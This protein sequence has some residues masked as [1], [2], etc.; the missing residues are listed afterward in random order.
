MVL[1]ASVALAFALPDED[2]DV[3]EALMLQ[4]EDTPALA[5]TIWI[6]EIASGLRT[7]EQRERLTEATSRAVLAQFAELHIE[8]EHPDAVRLVDL[9]RETGL[10]VYDAS[11]LALC[12]QHKLPLASFDRRLTSVALTRG[13][14]IRT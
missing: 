9:A 1:D 14:A 8:F 5:P 2:S 6:Y 10:S 3:A 12:E 4:L 13:I 7:A 11:Y